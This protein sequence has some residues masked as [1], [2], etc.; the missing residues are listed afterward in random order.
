[1]ARSAPPSRYAA[2]RPCGSRS[3]P[4]SPLLGHDIHVDRYICGAI[5]HLPHNGQLDGP[6]LGR[7]SSIAPASPRS[8][9]DAMLLGLPV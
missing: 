6:M 2:S 5:P 8:P 7:K 3:L 9:T 1:M 4:R